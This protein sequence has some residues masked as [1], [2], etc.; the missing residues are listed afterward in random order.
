M[1][2]NVVIGIGIEA[3][4]QTMVLILHIATTASGTQ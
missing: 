2:E 3:G 1:V 4:N